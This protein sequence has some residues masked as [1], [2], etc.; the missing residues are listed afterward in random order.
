MRE[1]LVNKHIRENKNTGWLIKAQTFQMSTNIKRH[2]RLT[3]KLR[4]KIFP[5][6]S[7]NLAN[8]IYGHFHFLLI[9][10]FMLGLSPPSLNWYSDFLV[11]VL[12]ILLLMI[13][14]CPHR[15]TMFSFDLDAF[16][17]TPSRP[18]V[19]HTLTTFSFWWEKSQNESQKFYFIF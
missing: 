15:L 17:S 4:R 8:D 7:F 19:H 3:L 1:H 9:S 13:P 12:Y 14:V 18:S 10:Y 2:K 11:V 6:L 16:D 5:F